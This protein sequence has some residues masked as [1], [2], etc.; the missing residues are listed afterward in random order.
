MKAEASKLLANWVDGARDLEE[1]ISLFDL[2]SDK[3]AEGALGAVL[4]ECP[5]LL[6]DIDLSTGEKCS[7]H[8]STTDALTH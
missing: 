8:A 3:T 4:A 1:F 2:S 7:R 6:N 5:E